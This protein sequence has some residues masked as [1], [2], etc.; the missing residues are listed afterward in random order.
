MTHRNSAFLTRAAVLIALITGAAGS[1]AHAEMHEGIW[2]QDFDGAITIVAPRYA[3]P[4]GYDVGI[5]YS[6]PGEHVCAL[7]G[8]SG[9]LRVDFESYDPQSMVCDLAQDGQLKSYFDGVTL[10]YG[11][12]SCAHS[13]TKAE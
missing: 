6:T 13:K 8:L 11:S 12:I 1:L 10:I 2:T 7:F 5:S 9:F 4:N 3:A